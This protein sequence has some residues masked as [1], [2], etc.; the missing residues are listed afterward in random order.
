VKINILEIQKRLKFSEEKTKNES[1]SIK[2][3]CLQ[4]TG[5]KLKTQFGFAAEKC[6][7]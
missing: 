3:L 2:T 4:E 1:N 5:I 6:T 7:K